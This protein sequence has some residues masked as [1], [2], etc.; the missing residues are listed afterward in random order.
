MV[1][2]GLCTVA[3]DATCFRS[4]N[5]PSRYNH[6]D[7]C[8]I[9][10]TAHEAVTLS[11][12]AFETDWGDYLTVAGVPYQGTRYLGTSGPDGVEVA[13]GASITFT[14]DSY[15]TRTGFEVCGACLR[16]PTHRWRPSRGP[17]ALNPRVSK[18]DAGACA[19]SQG[20][21]PRPSHRRRRP[22]RRSLPVRDHPRHLDG[23]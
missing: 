6:N 22:H 8:A 2:S 15:G 7:N 10:V 21:C 16:A 17:H 5:Y 9:T 18:A 20:R 11:V 19:Q 13:A 1:D 12:T 3:S 23:R 14:S 4:P